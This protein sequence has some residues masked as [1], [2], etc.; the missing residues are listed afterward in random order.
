MTKDPT[1]PI[2]RSSDILIS[3]LGLAARPRRLMPYGQFPATK[4]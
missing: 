2:A 4:P 3:L 1:M